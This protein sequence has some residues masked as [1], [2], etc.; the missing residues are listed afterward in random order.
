M[1]NN[2]FIATSKLILL[3]F[4]TGAQSSASINV[5]FPVKEIIVKQ[6]VFCDDADYVDLN[7]FGCINTNLVNGCLAIVSCTSGGSSTLG[8]GHMAVPINN[9]FVFKNPQIINGTYNFEMRTIANAIFPFTTAN[10]K[11][12]LI[13]EFVAERSPAMFVS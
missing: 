8:F 7:S 12:G 6:A 3:S 1:N 10:S 2:E 4:D 11:V 5:N 13:V 9:R